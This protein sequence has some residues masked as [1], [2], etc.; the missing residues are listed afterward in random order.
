MGM[1]PLQLPF[2][3]VAVSSNHAHPNTLRSHVNHPKPESQYGAGL[4]QTFR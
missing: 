4:Q 1:V 3:G 2:D